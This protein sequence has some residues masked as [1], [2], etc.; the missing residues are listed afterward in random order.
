MI[1]KPAVED[2]PQSQPANRFL[3]GIL[4]A[5]FGFLALASAAMIGIISFTPFNPPDWARFSTFALFGVGF[6]G[7]A[8]F[9]ALSLRG[10]GRVWAVV[11][12]ALIA[13]T[14]I[15]CLTMLFQP[16]M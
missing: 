16:G 3:L 8:I 14:T 7:S 11:G 4:S 6:L 10:R 9:G 1:N 12:L 13:L 2:R 5:I 15:A